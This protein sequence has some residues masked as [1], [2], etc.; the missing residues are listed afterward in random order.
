MAWYLIAYLVIFVS[1]GV[2]GIVEDCRSRRPGLFVL[3]MTI[4]LAVG[5]LWIF[6]FAY[7]SLGDTLGRWLWPMF[8]FAVSMELLSMARDLR[9][10]SN[11]GETSRGEAVISTL[12]VLA[13]TLP[14]YAM[15]VVVAVRS[16]H[17]IR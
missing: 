14:S 3:A 11:D 7:P 6:A 4:T 15:G 1:L 10:M 12:I 17:V 16:G 5:V 13:V 9:D 8:A 2:T